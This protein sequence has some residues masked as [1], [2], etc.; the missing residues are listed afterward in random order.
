[1]IREGVTNILKHASATCCTVQLTAGHLL[2]T[3]DGSGE[4]GSAPPG[5]GLRNLAARLEAA[6]GRLTAT[7]EGGT[8]SLSA[9][10]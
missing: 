7:R 4:A 6:G 10:L 9:E 1:V 8:F 5:Q 2:I 3:N